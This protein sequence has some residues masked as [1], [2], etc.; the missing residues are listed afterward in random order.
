[1]IVFGDSLCDGGNAHALRADPAVPCPPLV[2]SLGG[3]HNHAYGGA[4]SGLGYVPKGMPNRQEQ[5]EGFLRSE[6]LAAVVGDQ[7]DPA[8]PRQR[9]A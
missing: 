9:G 6:T 1:L 3:G 2:H 5:V 8:A 4:R 7:H